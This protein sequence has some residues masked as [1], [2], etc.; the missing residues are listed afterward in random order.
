MHLFARLIPERWRWAHRW[1]AWLAQYAW[2]PCPLCSEPFGGHE[3]RDIN[4]MIS[5]T[6]KPGGGHTAICPTCTRTSRGDRLP[7]I[8]FAAELDST[9]TN[10]GE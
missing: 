1:F 10:Q 8:S 6:P 4:G 7:Y 9:R 3:W 5:A 2:L